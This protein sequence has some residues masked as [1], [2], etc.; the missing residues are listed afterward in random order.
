MSDRPLVER[1]SN[2]QIPKFCF[3][4]MAAD[5]EGTWFALR[6]TLGNIEVWKEEV[7]NDLVQPT[8]ATDRVLTS[9]VLGPRGE[10]IAVAA[11]SQLSLWDTAGGPP[12]KLLT[13]NGSVIRALACSPRDE[14]VAH[15]TDEGVRIWD[16]RSNQIVCSIPERNV[17]ALSFDN[18][19]VR[20]VVGTTSGVV[21]S[22]D[23]ASGKPF[24]RLQAH[25]QEVRCIA[26]SA[27]GRTMATGSADHHLILWSVSPLAPLTREPM[28]HAG[29]IRHVAFSPDTDDSDSRFVA[30]AGN[31]GTICIWD[32]RSGSRV[33]RLQEKV[34]EVKGIAFSPD[35][36]RI[37]SLVGNNVRIWDWEREYELVDFAKL[38]LPISMCLT[39]DGRRLVVADRGGTIH[40]WL[41]T[42][43]TPLTRGVPGSGRHETDG[44]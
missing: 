17:S 4:R 39:H 30:T 44:I 28:T 14:R 27:Q 22:W 29:E 15:G 40:Q 12:K 32:C 37:L 16:T 7:T 9:V 3:V 5:D 31:D 6:S 13:G 34:A 42:G 26:F 23:P 2:P 18:R 11:G 25:R 38:D 20:L 10:Q 19:G 43:K 36:R 33:Q 8:L 41:N 1:N 24:E 21:R 35:G